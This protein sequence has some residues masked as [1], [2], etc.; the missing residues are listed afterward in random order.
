MQAVE[1]ADKSRITVNQGTPSMLHVVYSS[2]KR[3][4]VRL[5]MQLP[6][7]KETHAIC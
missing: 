5:V 4:N 6:K 3:P 1:I 2:F 7:A